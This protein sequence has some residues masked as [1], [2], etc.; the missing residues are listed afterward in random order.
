[1]LPELKC[2]AQVFD[3]SFHPQQDIIATGVVNGHLQLQKYGETGHTKL[4]DLKLHDDAVRCARFTADGTAL[5]S[6]S[7]DK[8]I[9]R[10]DATGTVTWAQAT[11]HAAPVNVVTPF[12]GYMVASGDDDGV[13]RIWDT[14]TPGTAPVSFDKQEDVISDVYVDMDRATMLASCC[15]GTLAVFDLR[16]ARMVAKTEQEEDELLSLCIIKGGKTVVAGTQEGLLLSWQWGKWTFADDDVQYGPERFTGHPESID[17]IL[18][19]DDDTIVTGSSDGILR[20]LTIKPNKLVGVL[21]EHD[22][23]PVE[24]LAWSRDKRYIGSVSHD[25]SVKFWDVAYLF[26]EDEESEEEEERDGGAARAR[27]G[28]NKKK[29][30][31]SGAGATASAGSRFL[32]MPELAMPDREDEDDDDDMDED[33]DDEDMDEGDNA[34]AS[35]AAAGGGAAGGHDEED[36]SDDDRRVKWKRKPSKS[37]PAKGKGKKGGNGGFYAGLDDDL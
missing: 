35:N 17:A 7:T 12:A 33:S 1:M 32:D 11:A 14:R 10:V 34:G 9:K 8:S 24:R 2:G 19:V 30:K 6:G 3:L 5:F 15:D 22:D 26:Q 27:K 20:L 37:K 18:S 36:D 21:G 13:V 23:F 31:A 29:S 28:A 16:K 25:Q 4:V